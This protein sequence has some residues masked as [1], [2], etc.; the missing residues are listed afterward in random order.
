MLC[1]I[2]YQ[3]TAFQLSGVN[4]HINLVHSDMVSANY[5]EDS[6]ICAITDSLKSS[7]TSDPALQQIKSLRNQY[8][9]DLVGVMTSNRATSC[10]CG[11]IPTNASWSKDTSELAYFVATV[12]CATSQYSFAHEI[13]HAFVSTNILL[14][15]CIRMY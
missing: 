13:A 4:A 1:E 8:G 11:S 5:N 2:N 12:Q 6:N 3:N 10:G 9:A 14:T 15:D 7:S